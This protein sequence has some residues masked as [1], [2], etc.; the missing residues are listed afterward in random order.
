MCALAGYPEFLRRKWLLRLMSWQSISTSG[1]FGRRK[2]LPP[3]VPMP[4]KRYQRR[5]KDNQQA[6]LIS[7]NFFYDQGKHT[8]DK[9]RTRYKRS[10]LYLEDEVTREKCWVH[11]T[12]VGIAALSM[13]LRYLFDSCFNEY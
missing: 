10:D 2:R 6:R 5:Q 3:T 8:K 7:E 12:S 4:V 11:F 9:E 13:H 1:C